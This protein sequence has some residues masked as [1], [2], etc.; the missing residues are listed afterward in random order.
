MRGSR[1]L[2]LLV[3]LAVLTAFTVT[4]LDYRAGAGSS[5]FDVVRRASDATLG[6]V[7]RAIGGAVN[8]A[9]GALGLGTDTDE[10]RR[11]RDDNDR[12]RAELAQT[13]AL[14]TQVREWNSLLALKDAADLSVVPARVVAF[15]SS[16]G[17]E[18]T[19]TIDAGARDGIKPGQTVV[20]GKGLVGRTKRV[21]DTTSVIVLLT[22]R[23][24]S[25]GVRM[26]RT[27]R[28]GLATGDGASGLTYQLLGQNDRAEVGDA[29]VTSGS[30]TY[31]AG[32]PVG[33]VSAIDN[34][35]NALTRTGRLTPYADLGSL[36]LVGV[37]LAGP[38]E[39]PRA[40]LPRPT[41]PRPTP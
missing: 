4:A 35:P 1:S 2:R 9:A 10:V 32:L 31:V 11:L 8:G 26:A 7:Q 14:R 27:G 15:G 34:D 16:L 18:R 24:V 30:T 23:D 39:S 17:F 19:A 22:D 25:V 20:T 37:V 28:L 5:P 13:D 38:R 33:R 21:A 29:V 41:L 36:D 12:L 40:P 3:V 6:P